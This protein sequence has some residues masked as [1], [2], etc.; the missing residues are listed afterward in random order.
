MKRSYA[1]FQSSS[2]PFCKAKENSDYSDCFF[3]LLCHTTTDIFHACSITTYTYTGLPF[4]V[5]LIRGRCH[6][7]SCCTRSI[8]LLLGCLSLKR[9]QSFWRLSAGG[10]RRK[11]DR[12]WDRSR[13][14]WVASLGQPRKPWKL[15]PLQY[16]LFFERTR[17]WVSS[18]VALAS[19]DSRPFSRNCSSGLQENGEW[20]GRC[21]INKEHRYHVVSLELDKKIAYNLI[22]HCF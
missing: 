1:A 13:R 18:D 6:C 19:N 15:S 22:I 5:V 2:H 12:G 3:T 10:V 21:R 8:V 17:L 11:T 20:R 9:P 7:A 4:T 16:T 14:L